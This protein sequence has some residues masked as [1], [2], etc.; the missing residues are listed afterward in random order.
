MKEFGCEV[1]Y[2]THSR[3]NNP[4]GTVEPGEI[5][6]VNTEL[7]TGKWLKSLNDVFSNDKAEGPNVCVCIKVAGAKPGD[8]LA[9]KILDITPENM[10]YTGFEGNYGL[11]GLI[12]FRPW[13]LATKTV[14]IS[15]GYVNWSS[16]LKI[17]ISPMIGTLG[18]APAIEEFGNAWGG[19]HGANMDVQEVC[20]GTTI[21]LPVNVEGALL[22]VGD[23]H[24]IQ[25]DAEICYNGGIEC[26][27]RVKLQV[28]LIHQ[29]PKR[30]CIR[31]EDEQFI[32]TVC[33]TR[34]LEEAF[35]ISAGEILDW[36]VDEYG[37]EYEE[38]YLLMGQV[39]QARATQFVNPTRSYICKFPKKYLIASN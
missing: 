25:G 33:C 37:F 11:Q 19:A 26:R 9:V 31:M 8:A 5:F 34:S 23:V 30:P 21:Y 13:G 6:F 16:K 38:A 17:P 32:M 27:S 18:T 1:V 20:A 35:Y 24:A 3:F 14:S 4:A 22:H 39:L 10:G 36:M 7:N 15:D 29:P 28:E 12:K 2:D